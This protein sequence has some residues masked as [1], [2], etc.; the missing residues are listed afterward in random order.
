M[1]RTGNAMRLARLVSLLI[2]ALLASAAARAQSVR[3][4]PSEGG[5]A[6]SAVQLVFDNCAP[7]GQPD[8]PSIPGVTFTFVDE[9]Q[10]SQASFGPGGFTQTRTV[11]L[12]YLIR[13]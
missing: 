12:T 6:S 10:S 2:F 5:M 4:V 7:D 3:W 11:T 9:S 13:A 1:A 8:L